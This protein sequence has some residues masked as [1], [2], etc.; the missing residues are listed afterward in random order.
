MQLTVTINV[1]FYLPVRH[2]VRLL[3]HNVRFRLS[4]TGHTSYLKIDKL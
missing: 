3:L 1:F 2:F 4:G